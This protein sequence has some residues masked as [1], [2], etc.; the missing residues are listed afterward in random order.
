MLALWSPAAI[1]LAVA[2]LAVAVAAG[3]RAVEQ[4]NAPRPEAFEHP[5]GAPPP[6]R[7]P[8]VEPWVLALAAIAVAGLVLA[9]RLF[10]I[11]FLFLPFLF[12]NRRRWS[13]GGRDRGRPPGGDAAS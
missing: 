7:K 3:F 9:P 1:C 12:G 5:E 13:S 8:L 4:R 10:G 6:P 11:T 2:A